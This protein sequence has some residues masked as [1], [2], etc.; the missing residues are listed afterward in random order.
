MDELRYMMSAYL[1]IPLESVIV[2]R[3]SLREATVIVCEGQGK[4]DDMID[5]INHD[6]T[7]FTGSVLEGARVVGVLYGVKCAVGA[8]VLPP[9]QVD[10]S[11]SDPSP[12]PLPSSVH[13]I[14]FTSGS[15]NSV[16]VS[17]AL[18]LLAATFLLF[19]L[20]L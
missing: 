4:V 15:T 14:P 1:D 16:D 19:A 10:Y 2:T 20:Y 9:G 8:Q 3:F 5:D 11:V 6:G 12:D 17:A 7:F 13:F 18:L